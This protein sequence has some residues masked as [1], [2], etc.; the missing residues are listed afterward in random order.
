MTDT[1]LHQGAPSYAPEPATIGVRWETPDGATL[2][3]LIN[4][5]Q[6]HGEACLLCTRMNGELMDAGH[7]YTQAGGGWRAKVCA[8]GCQEAAA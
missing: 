7:V 5:T 1:T 4:Q 3:F 8:D 2:E 6:L